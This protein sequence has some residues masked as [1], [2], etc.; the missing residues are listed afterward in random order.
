MIV[1]DVDFESYFFP[2]CSNCSPTRT[3]LS[4]SMILRDLNETVVK[5]FPI[6]LSGKDDYNES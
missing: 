5:A 4:I 6:V 2:Q 3:L 1:N